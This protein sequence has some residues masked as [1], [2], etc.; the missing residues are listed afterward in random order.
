MAADPD[1]SL[2][3]DNLAKSADLDQRTRLKTEFLRRRMETDEGAQR[4]V[5]QISRAENLMSRLI[6]RDFERRMSELERRVRD[7]ETQT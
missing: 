4:T 2:L 7:L 1:I 5:R 6:A 3:R